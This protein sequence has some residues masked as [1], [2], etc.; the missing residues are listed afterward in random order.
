M[1]RDSNGV[2][3][4]AI[5]DRLTRQKEFVEAKRNHDASSVVSDIS[6]SLSE[7]YSCKFEPPEDR[8]NLCPPET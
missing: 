8:N 3:V 4:K 1:I 5:K 7:P 6:N 2:L